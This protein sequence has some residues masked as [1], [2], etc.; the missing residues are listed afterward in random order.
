GYANAAPTRRGSGFVDVW[1]AAPDAETRRIRAPSRLSASGPG[2]RTG[3]DPRR[4]A[5]SLIDQ[6]G[7]AARGA[8]GSMTTMSN[9]AMG[10]SNR[11]RSH[12]FN[13]PRP[14]DWASPALISESVPHPTTKPPDS[15]AVISLSVQVPMLESSRATQWHWLE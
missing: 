10:P 12:Q 7:L 1:R 8:R 11:D 2:P 6:P 13:P 15:A 4:Q 3:V 9:V 5:V 14:L